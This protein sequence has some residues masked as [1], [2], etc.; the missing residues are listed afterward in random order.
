VRG[1]RIVVPERNLVGGG[2]VIL[3]HDRTAPGRKSARAE[4]SARSD[5]G[6]ARK[7]PPPSARPALHGGLAAV[8]AGFGSRL[9]AWSGSIGT[10][11]RLRRRL[12][13]ASELARWVAPTF[14]RR[15][16]DRWTRV[17]TVSDF[18]GLALRRTPRSVFD[19]VEGAAESE[20]SRDRAVEAFARSVFHPHVL[21]DVSTV[22]T[23]TTIL[24]RR[25]ALP[26]V[27]GPT[28]FTRMMHAA[29]EPA[30]ARAA[31]RAGVPYTLSTLGTTSVER[32]AA[33]T[34]NTERWFQ[35]Y[36]SKDRERSRDLIARAAE[37]A[38]S[39]LVLTVDV[40]VAGAR[41]RDVYNGLTLPPTLTPRT[42]VGMLAKPRW[43]FDALTTEPLAFESLGAA[44]DVMTL[45]N[46]VFD[47]SVTFADIEWLRSQWSGSIVVKGIQRVDDSQ[48][49]VAAGANGVAV[50]NHG[51][52]QLDRAVTPLELLPAVV[53]AV[54]DRAEVYLDGGV[55]SGADVAI[56]VALGAQA[57]FVARP[58]LYALM[59]GG[60]VGVDHLMTLLH[61]DY[62]RTLRL[63][64]VT[65]TAELGRDHVE[66]AGPHVV[67]GLFPEPQCL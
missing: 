19:Y 59:A 53:D 21:R 63:L 17:R 56:A 20:L 3:V 45:I 34:P 36:V 16:R 6:R 58:Y 5:P 8:L 64:G 50:S 30:V 29:G 14:R 10:V 35:L 51:G 44:S 26:V 9:A 55:R 60:E 67:T 46:S 18:R 38:Y 52:R 42:L 66:L 27:L 62:A 40:P 13:R 57:V 47:P 15:S 12:P 61:T 11:S 33:E 37:S 54:S 31:G 7:D 39:T 32:L 4:R 28:G 1:E 49:V 2:D 22:D 25:A 43:L 48:A 65:R 41:L 23:A 24:G